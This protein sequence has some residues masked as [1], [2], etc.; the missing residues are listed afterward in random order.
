MDPESPPE[1]L[2]EF[3]CDF[4]I[5]VMGDAG[6]DF[7]ALVAALVRRHAP[8]L[9][10]ARLVIRHSRGGRYQSVTVSVHAASRAQ[11]DAIYRELTGHERVVWVL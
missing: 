10:E 8:D 5:K 4:A 9:E 3:P 1:S 7:P 6:P 11:L 2:M